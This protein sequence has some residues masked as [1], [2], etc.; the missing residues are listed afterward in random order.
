MLMLER[1]LFLLRLAIL[2]IWDVLV[3]FYGFL[4]QFGRLVIVVIISKYIFPC[5]RQISTGNLLR[6]IDQLSRL[7]HIS[8]RRAKKVFSGNYLILRK[9]HSVS[10]SLQLKVKYERIISNN[11]NVCNISATMHCNTIWEKLCSVIS[12]KMKNRTRNYVYH[13]LNFEKN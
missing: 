11:R 5:L 7:K 4:F 10:A 2:D 8:I 1:S 13:E 12:S 6:A 3:L 9:I